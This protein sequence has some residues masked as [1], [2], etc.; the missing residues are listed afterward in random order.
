MARRVC[1]VCEGKGFVKEKKGFLGW[2][3]EGSTGVRICP[4][5][6]GSKWVEE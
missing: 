6:N 4:R 5:C 2:L 1:P 3:I